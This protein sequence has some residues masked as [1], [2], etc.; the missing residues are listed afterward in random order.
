MKFSKLLKS[1]K[2]LHAEEEDENV[3]FRLAACSLRGT[4]NRWME[5][6]QHKKSKDIL[7]KLNIERWKIL[8]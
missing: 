8:T 4:L 5:F 6:V 3:T 7:I 1:E 2:L